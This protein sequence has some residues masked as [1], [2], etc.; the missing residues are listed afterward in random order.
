MTTRY[1]YYFHIN[2]QLN[3]LLSLM[4]ALLVD[5][6]LNKAKPED[7]RQEACVIRMKMRF[8][9]D[10]KPLKSGYERCGPRTMEERRAL[11][12]CFYLSSCVSF[13]YALVLLDLLSLMPLDHLMHAIIVCR[14]YTEA[15]LHGRMLRSD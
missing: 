5:L 10:L 4:S 9:T 13:I 12:G 1:Q 7:G 15:P 2:M 6:G 14:L 3:N 11:L 8:K